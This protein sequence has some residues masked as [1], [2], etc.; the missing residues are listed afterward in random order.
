M[1]KEKIIHICDKCQ[2]E[3]IS[4]KDIIEIFNEN[5][6]CTSCNKTIR[7]LTQTIE[8][9]PYEMPTTYYEGVWCRIS[10]RLLML[11]MDNLQLATVT[12]RIRTTVNNI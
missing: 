3:I 9:T 4:S 8:L 5:L 1:N 6:I 11:P 7:E 10:D 12:Q 2:Y